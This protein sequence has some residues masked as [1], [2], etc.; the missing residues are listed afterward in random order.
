[1]GIKIL[2]SNLSIFKWEIQFRM[3]DSGIFPT[4]KGSLFRGVFGKAFKKVSCSMYHGICSK[5]IISDECA[6]FQIFDLENIEEKNKGR[7]YT[8]RPYSLRE[9]PQ[10]NRFHNGELITIG[11]NLF[12]ETNKHFIPYLLATFDLMGSYKFGKNDLQLK[13]ENIT[14]LNNHNSIYNTK[15]HPIVFDNI[16]EETIPGDIESMDLILQTPLR[17]KFHGKQIY[18]L[19]KYSLLSTIINRYKTLHECFGTFEEEDLMGI[20]DFELISIQ[21]KV[22]NNKR[23]STRQNKKLYLPGILGNYRIISKNKKLFY[24]L[25]RLENLQIGKSTTFGFGQF[26]III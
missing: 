25:K 11:F 14:D 15:D 5:C 26:K 7:F 23:F 9:L 3:M 17:I 1:M 16:F 24:I 13:L 4:F 12:G 18:N 21:E 20:E 19:D 2:K 10:K 22:T 8:P 6:Y